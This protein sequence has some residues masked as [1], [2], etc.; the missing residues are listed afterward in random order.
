M[1]ENYN[2]TLIE[3]TIAILEYD[4]T[5]NRAELMELFRNI[6]SVNL[7]LQIFFWSKTGI[8]KPFY[9]FK[10]PCNHKW[11]KKGDSWIEHL[12]ITRE[13]FDNAIKKIGTKITKGISKK[14]IFKKMKFN[15]LV[16]YWTDK[17]RV[18]YYQLNENMVLVLMDKLLNCPSDKFKKALYI[19][20]LYITYTDNRTKKNI[21]I[22]SDERN[23][24]T[25][26]ISN[27]SDQLSLSK[28][29]CTSDIGNK[30]PEFKSL[31][32]FKEPLENIQIFYHF[33][34]VYQD[35]LFKN[36][37]FISRSKINEGLMVIRDIKELHRLN[38]EDI[39]EMVNYFILQVK[40]GFVISNGRW[41]HFCSPG[42]LEKL[43]KQVIK[44][45]YFER[46][47]DGGLYK[48]IESNQI[49]NN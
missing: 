1:S 15:T 43:Y 11:Y 20:T 27:T 46:Y 18:T 34:N 6:N 12:K 10:Q 3:N 39:K 7:F 9:K 22:L 19:E 35:T 42:I 47:P 37:P 45:F 13:K 29:I 16:I 24:K 2:K 48:K 41:N 4:M 5:R 31:K 40:N 23:N 30:V 32:Q 44:S 17:N 8:F 21:D 28:P 49:S 25:S 36:H 26:L 33:I 14:E 38:D